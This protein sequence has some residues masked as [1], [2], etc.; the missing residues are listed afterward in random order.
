MNT[1]DEVQGILHEIN[2]GVPL[3][4][5]PADGFDEDEYNRLREELTKHAVLK[6]YV[7]LYSDRKVIGPLI[8]LFKKIIRRLSK[9]L[10]FPLIEQQ[11]EFNALMIRSLDL[12]HYSYGSKRR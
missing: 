8:V 1:L 2:T 5:N 6:Y 12:L 10:I 9:N 3:G 4:D 7:P 11:N